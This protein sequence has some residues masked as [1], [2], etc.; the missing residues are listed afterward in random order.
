MRGRAGSVVLVFAWL[1][2]WGL[3]HL[4]GLFIFL[5]FATGFVLVA[6]AW[7]TRD[8]AF[9]RRPDLEVPILLPWGRETLRHN[10]RARLLR[11]LGALK[12]KQQGCERLMNEIPKDEL[13]R[14]PV[15]EAE[16]DAAARELVRV[17][18]DLARLKK[19]WQREDREREYRKL[20]A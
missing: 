12:E 2:T 20:T 9:G 15:L 7:G 19:T 1:G 8:M 10:A 4:H 16:R 3:S 13:T 6:G 5:V 11:Q 14:V 17:N 18:D